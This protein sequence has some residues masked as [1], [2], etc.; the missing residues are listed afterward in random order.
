MIEIGDMGQGSKKKVNF[1]RRKGTF[2]VKR[3]K[4]LRKI[5]SQQVCRE[6]GES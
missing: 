6:R 3:M 4:G 5:Y 1:N 2:I